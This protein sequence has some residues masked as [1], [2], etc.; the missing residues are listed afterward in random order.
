MNQGN[1]P[2][3]YY[4]QP[5][6]PPPPM[7]PSQMV[8]GAGQAQVQPQPVP[9]Q[10]PPQV[11]NQPQQIQQ[12][13]QP[14]LQMGKNVIPPQQPGQTPLTESDF[15]TDGLVDPILKVKELYGQFKHSLQVRL[16]FNELKIKSIR[17]IKF[18]VNSF[19]MRKK[20]KRA[21]W[22]LD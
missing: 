20:I 16:F 6:Q 13:P 10:A 14:Q 1:P 5:Q 12:P 19:L 2:P 21:A 17:I 22:I 18:L 4:G 9:V 11:P 3:G 7:H 15:Q 8:V